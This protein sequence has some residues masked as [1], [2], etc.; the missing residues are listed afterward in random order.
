MHANRVDSETTF[1]FGRNKKMLKAEK[2]TGV[3]LVWSFLRGRE[4]MHVSHR[5]IFPL[6]ISQDSCRFDL[7]N[8]K[9]IIRAYSGVSNSIRSENIGDCL[10][11]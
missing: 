1:K 4:P 5:K 2:Q 11:L 9:D 7:P 3:R 10:K 6:Y 8:F